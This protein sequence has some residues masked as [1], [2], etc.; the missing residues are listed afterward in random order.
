MLQSSHFSSA[1][2]NNK[3]HGLKLSGFQFGDCVQGWSGGQWEHG[4]VR[5]ERRRVT[6]GRTG[7]ASRIVA[8][9]A[10]RRGTTVLHD[11]SAGEEE[12]V[13]CSRPDQWAVTV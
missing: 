4:A 3:P 8:A 13:Q 6:I 11:R 12:A 1:I 9:S 10:D 2:Q 7:P 5:G